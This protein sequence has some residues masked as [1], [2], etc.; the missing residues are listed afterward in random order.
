M[1]G[2]LT[3]LPEKG[4]GLFMYFSFIFLFLFR[5][6]V[7][8]QENEPLSNFIETKKKKTIFYAFFGA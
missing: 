7:Y 3:K 2:I 4:F 1:K 5:L 8:K 6:P